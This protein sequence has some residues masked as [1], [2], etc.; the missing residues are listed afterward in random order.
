MQV[1]GL[2]EISDSLS[3]E[4]PHSAGHILDSQVKG[5]QLIQPILQL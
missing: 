4:H 2:M 1:T 5:K 3:A